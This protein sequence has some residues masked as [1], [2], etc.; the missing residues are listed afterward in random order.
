MNKETGRPDPKEEDERR[1]AEA[2]AVLKRASAG[3]ET[4]GASQL[5]QQGRAAIDGLMGEQGEGEDHIDQWGR[6]IGRG[7]GL[8]AVIVLLIYLYQTYIAA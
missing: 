1:I 6:L 2:E 5:A 3:T 4:F 7:L 8:V